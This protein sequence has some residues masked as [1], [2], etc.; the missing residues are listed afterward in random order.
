MI[1]NRNPRPHVLV[2]LGLLGIA[3]YQLALRL[4]HLEIMENDF[5]HGAWFGICLGLEI[6]GLIILRKGK[7]NQA[8]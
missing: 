6:L 8:A 3:A 4:F 1:L 7:R 5:I 2:A